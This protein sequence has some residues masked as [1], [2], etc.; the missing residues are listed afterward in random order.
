LRRFVAT[1]SG[2]DFLAEAPDIDGVARSSAS[3]GRDERPR[4][5]TLSRN[6][7]LRYAAQGKV[8]PVDRLG[9]FAPVARQM[10]KAA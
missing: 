5:D 10:R 4:I 6:R 9:P 1:S 2:S 3:C 8:P 7:R